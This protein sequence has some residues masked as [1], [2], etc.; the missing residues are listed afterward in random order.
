MKH[1]PFHFFA[2]PMRTYVPVYVAAAEA[3]RTGFLPYIFDIFG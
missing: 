1:N 2:F 3:L